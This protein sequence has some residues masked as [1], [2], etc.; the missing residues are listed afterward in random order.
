MEI[1]DRIKS[2]FGRKNA[3]PVVETC[4]RYQ[5][6]SGFIDGYNTVFAAILKQKEKNYGARL[7]TYK[8]NGV[9]LERCLIEDMPEDRWVDFKSKLNE[10]MTKGYIEC[11]KQQIP[12]LLSEGKRGVYAVRVK[13]YIGGAFVEDGANIY[14]TD[15]N[16]RQSFVRSMNDKKWKKFQNLITK[17]QEEEEAIRKASLSKFISL[18]EK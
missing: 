18:G 3:S 13:R 12:L 16:L 6:P 2:F 1:K 7:Y 11:G 8:E 9:S 4:Q 14:Q 10:A 5:I 15:E 17:A